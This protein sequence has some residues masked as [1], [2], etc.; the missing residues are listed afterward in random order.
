MLFHPV[1]F[2]RD[3]NLRGE[4]LQ[5]IA[6]LVWKAVHHLQASITT[7]FPVADGQ[8]PWLLNQKILSLSSLA[9]VDSTKSRVYFQTSNAK[10]TIWWNEIMAITWPGSTEW[11]EEPRHHRASLFF[12]RHQAMAISHRDERAHTILQIMFRQSHATYR[13]TVR[14]HLCLPLAGGLPHLLALRPD[15]Q[16]VQA[17]PRMIICPLE[18]YLPNQKEI[19]ITIRQL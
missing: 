19:T 6:V 18:A 13:V 10:T 1:V 17:R 11:N 3:P 12:T 16:L 4:I 8:E 5:I 7:I 9:L 2:P 15:F 14:Y